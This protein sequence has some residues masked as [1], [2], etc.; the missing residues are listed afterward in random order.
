MSSELEHAV[1]GVVWRA[2]PCTA[3]AVRKV[4]RESPS[5]HWSG[6]AGAI[7]P[8]VRRLEGRELLRSVAKRG[9]RRATRLYRLTAKGR[10]VLRTWLR[11]PLPP[12]AS[13]MDVDPLRVRLLFIGALREDEQAAVLAEARERLREQLGRLEEEVRADRAAGDRYRYFVSRGAVLSVRAQ[14]AWLDEVAAALRS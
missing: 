13:L 6:S 5:S 2:E 7:Y 12:G 1:L 10:R 9:D 11:P 14:L 8:L 4:F 3:Y